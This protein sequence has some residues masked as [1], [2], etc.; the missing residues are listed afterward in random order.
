MSLHKALLVGINAYPGAPLRGCIN[1]TQQVKELLTRFYGFMESDF[2]IMTDQEATLKGILVGL[3]WLAEGGEALQAVRVFHYSGHG[4]YVLDTNGDEPDGRDECLVPYDYQ[5][6]GMLTDDALKVVYD[7]FPRQGNL[8]LIMDS[9]HSGSCQKDV[10]ED[11]LYRFLPVG[12]AEQEQM[13]QAAAEFAR[14]QRDFVVNELQRANAGSL[15]DDELS[16]KV[17]VLMQ[18]FEKKRFGDIRVREANILLAGC[19]P[20]QQSADA[21]LNGEYHG[22]FTYFMAETIQE[23]QGQIT[24]YELARQVGLRLGKAHFAQI[25]QLECRSKN[26]MRMVF[27]PLDH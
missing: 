26:R 15:S 14:A 19:R 2:C 17:D 5:T 13:D 10:A 25:P 12:F 7:R 24:H 22:A 3:N 1:D 9:C 4:S 18:K 20:D 21:S 8:T 6:N 27:A 16:R 11:I 23:A